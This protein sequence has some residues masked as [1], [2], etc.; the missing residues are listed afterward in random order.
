MLVVIHCLL[1]VWINAPPALVECT[2]E[3][4]PATAEVRGDE[5]S[6]SAPKKDRTVLAGV[7]GSMGLNDSFNAPVSLTGHGRNEKH[8]DEPDVSRALKTTPAAR[9]RVFRNVSRGACGQPG[10]TGPMVGSKRH[11]QSAC[12]FNESRAVSAGGD[13]CRLQREERHVHERVLQG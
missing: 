1:T 4:R 13:A 12:D 11:R 2:I 9:E 5:T 3:P 10:K 8:R 7:W 6:K